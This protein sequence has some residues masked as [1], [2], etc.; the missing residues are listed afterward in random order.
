MSDIFLKPFLDL[1]AADGIKITISDYSRITL[2]LRAGGPWSL[3]CLRGVLLALLVKSPEEERLFLQRFESFFN[4]DLNTDIDTEFLPLPQPVK[5]PLRPIIVELSPTEIYSKSTNFAL[6][7]K[8]YNFST[9]ASIIFDG[10]TVSTQF[11]S[12]EQLSADVPAALIKT[13]G[14]RK[15][16]VQDKGHDSNVVTLKVDRKPWPLYRH[17]S[18]IALGALFLLAALTYY[19]I[20]NRPQ[21]KPEPDVVPPIAASPSPTP[22]PPPPSLDIW[23][24]AYIA[25]IATLI[26]LVYFFLRRLPSK[27]RPLFDPAAP[28]HFNLGLIGGKPAPFLDSTTLDYL[29]GLVGYGLSKVNSGSL[30]MRASVEF[31]ARA[32]GLPTL[33]YCKQKLIK[34]IYIIEDALAESSVWNSVPRELA[35]GLALRGVPVIYG[36]FYDSMERF[37]LADGTTYWLEELDTQN[38]NQPMIVFSDG[39]G[40]G[41]AQG[42]ALRVLARRS[43]LAWMELREPRFWDEKTELIARH[44]IPV[45]PATGEGTLQALN[46]FQTEQNLPVTYPRDN[47]PRHY[48]PG[49]SGEDISFRVERLLG[50]A[51]PWAQASAMIQP[52]TL[53]L[54]DSLRCQFQPYL[55]S[56]RIGRLFVLPGTTYSNSVLRFS[57]PVLAVLRSGFAM[58]WDD[59]KQEEI[60]KYILKKI[61]EVE[62]PQQN[63]LAHLSWQW[64]AARVRLE[65]DPNGALADIERLIQTPLGNHIKAEVENIYVADPALK[66]HAKTAPVRIPVRRGSER[67]FPWQRLA[68]INAEYGPKNRERDRFM[69]NRWEQVQ[70][71]ALDPLML[72]KHTVEELIGALERPIDDYYHPRSMDGQEVRPVETPIKDY[73]EKILN[74][75]RPAR[76][77]PDAG[78]DRKAVSEEAPEA[79][80]LMGHRG[81]LVGV[82]AGGSVGAVVNGLLGSSKEGLDWVTYNFTEPIGLLF[83][84]LMLMLIIPLVFSSVVISVAGIGDIRSLTRVA[85]KSFV[86]MLITSVIA[87]VIGLGVANTIRP[88]ARLA[89]GTRAGLEARYGAESARRIEYEQT[90]GT[91]DSPLSWVMKSIVPANPVAS[92]AGIVAG[93]ERQNDVPNMLHLMFFALFLGVGALFV[94]S[95]VSAPLLR[96]TQALYEISARV[97]E[98]V[99]RLAPFAFACLLFTATARFDG[100]LLGALLWFAVAVLLGL[101]LHMFGVYSLSV[102]FVSRLS[103]LEFFRRIRVVILTAFSTSSSYAT[104]PTALR[105]SEERLGV[106]REI[107]SFV[108]TV[109]SIGNQNG[110][111]LYVC[112]AVLFLVQAAGVNL[113]LGQQITV[114]FF[115]IL[116]GIG[117]TSTPSGSIPFVILM[118]A[119]YG[120]NPMIVA[121]ILGVD[122]IFGMCYATLNVA[123]DITAATY[124]ARSEGYE[125]LKVRPNSQS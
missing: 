23:V 20:V 33:V 25:L 1:L 75:R 104:L 69:D 36:K 6:N 105:V 49:F 57:D 19:V 9:S 82:I 107:N 71:L 5:S 48:M 41:Y 79:P 62:P 124:V 4:S 99:M 116:G 67:E 118:L 54:A 43:M 50:D 10:H 12:S 39:T 42:A 3:E 110:T 32:G 26:V 96:W 14:E 68:L 123:G 28:R 56:E 16:V 61:G 45:Y 22:T 94:P 35:E 64:V 101:A 125:L 65:L 77:A 90:T 112:V 53:G 106:P 122:R 17:K 29:A 46:R 15:I 80:N 97:T 102:Y 51:L 119:A 74:I 76:V 7:V 117:I 95:R 120:V 87:V 108:L 52:L 113:T 91:T 55:P 85:L 58:R 34:T 30:D 40:V 47:F 78:S 60:L 92:A 37:E 88:G 93:A 84:R 2:A 11:I 114:A 111:A 24:L 73:L 44:G 13:V 98:L 21:N 100:D 70:P 89:E 59:E 8:G 121:V 109:G 103:P 81:V 27:S 115:A 38:L 86:Y 66:R 63:S 18:L 72:Q 31:A 83:L